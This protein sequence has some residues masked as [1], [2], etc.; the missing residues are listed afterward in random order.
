M[1]PPRGKVDHS[2]HSEAHLSD[3]E[4]VDAA[5]DQVAAELEVR[6]ARQEPGHVPPWQTGNVMIPA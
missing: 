3:A 5:I 2:G 6:Q 1:H 4:L